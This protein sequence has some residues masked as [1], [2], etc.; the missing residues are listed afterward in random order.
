MSMCWCRPGSRRAN[1]EYLSGYRDRIRPEAVS[2]LD[3]LRLGNDGVE[4][5]DPLTNVSG[6]SPQRAADRYLAAHRSGVLP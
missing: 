5:I 6:L 2:S 1:G 4:E 3:A